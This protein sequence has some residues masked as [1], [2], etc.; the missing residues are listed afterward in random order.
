MAD[1]TLEPLLAELRNMID[2][3]DPLPPGVRAAAKASF[4]WRT[5]DALRF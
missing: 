3:V 4:A 2:R 1:Q 5:I